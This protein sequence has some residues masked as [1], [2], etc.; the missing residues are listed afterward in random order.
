MLWLL[1][2]A[3]QASQQRFLA[4]LSF[5]ASLGLH[6]SSSGLSDKQLL[7][8]SASIKSVVHR[9]LFVIVPIALDAGGSD[10]LFVHRLQSPRQGNNCIKSN[11]PSSSL[12]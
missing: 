2:L 6:S 7:S 4:L 11:Q 12:S 9:L 1:Q 10:L 8:L 5:Q 3:F